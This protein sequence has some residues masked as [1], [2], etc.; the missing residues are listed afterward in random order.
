MYDG[1]SCQQQAQQQ[2][3]PAQLLY[4]GQQRFLFVHLTK[5]ASG[6]TVAICE[7]YF[8]NQINFRR[9]LFEFVK[10]LTQ[11]TDR[12]T[13]VGN[14]LHRRREYLATWVTKRQTLLESHFHSQPTD[15]DGWF[16]L[17]VVGVLRM[18]TFS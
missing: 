10:V 1:K 7:T 13:T 11:Q 6:K 16:G 9:Q 18:M 14:G 2:Q 8:I 5:C 12:Q 17:I 15:N 3:K 4:T